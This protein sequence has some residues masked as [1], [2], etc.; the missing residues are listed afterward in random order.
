M[1]PE[2]VI[3]VKNVN[4]FYDELKT[5]INNNDEII[6]DLSKVKRIDLSAAQVIIAAGE[7]VKQLKKVLRI[8]GISHDLKK[9]LKLA[10]IQKKTK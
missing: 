9:I 6:L 7:K 3:D 4:G 10:G 2:G 5:E 8:T 1:K